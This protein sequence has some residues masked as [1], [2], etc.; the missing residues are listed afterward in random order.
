[1]QSTLQITQHPLD[2]API[3]LVRQPYSRGQKSSGGL[4]VPPHPRAQKQKLRRCTVEGHHLLF[5]QHL[6]QGWIS[7]REMM[8]RGRGR[9]RR[10]PVGL[11]THHL[12]SFQQRCETLTPSAVR[13]FQCL[14]LKE[15]HQW[16]CFVSFLADSSA[17]LPHFLS[18]ALSDIW[19]IT[20]PT[21]SAHR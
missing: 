13:D 7:H 9:F 12:V 17:S 11:S 20:I 2:L 14:G 15:F 8:V 19:A 10:R 18:A 5:R 4:N 6:S 21:T 3:I 16:S 1:M